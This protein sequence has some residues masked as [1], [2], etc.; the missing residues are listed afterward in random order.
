MAPRV[1]LSHYFSP[2]FLSLSTN[3]KV[4]AFTVQV[5]FPQGLMLLLWL[6]LFD[7]MRTYVTD[8]VGDG[9]SWFTK[10][11]LFVVAV[12]MADLFSIFAWLCLRLPLPGC[13][14]LERPRDF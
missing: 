4:Q 3:P 9:D 5:F 14:P 11:V 2:L 1:I 8:Y 10:F 13:S 12:P 6:Y 7:C